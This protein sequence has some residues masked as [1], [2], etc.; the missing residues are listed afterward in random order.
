MLLGEAPICPLV[1]MM[2]LF[3]LLLEQTDRLERL[4]NVFKQFLMVSF[5]D[6]K[7]IFYKFYLFF[8]VKTFFK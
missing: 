4:Q 5:D 6:I 1:V 2:V 3:E 8:S 7:P